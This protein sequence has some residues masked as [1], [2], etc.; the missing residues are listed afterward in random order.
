M[1]QHFRRGFASNFLERVQE[2]FDSQ[3]A[4]FVLVCYAENVLQARHFGFVSLQEP[5]FQRVNL[6]FDPI[7]RVVIDLAALSVRLLPPGTS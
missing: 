5:F 7:G 2:L 4:L 3:R 6:L 1:M